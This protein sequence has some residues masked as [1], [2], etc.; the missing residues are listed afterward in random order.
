MNLMDRILSPG[1]AVPE[2][3]Y[4]QFPVSFGKLIKLVDQVEVKTNVLKNIKEYQFPKN[5][6]QAVKKINKEPA[7]TC[8]PF[9]GSMDLTYPKMAELKSSILLDISR[10]GLDILEVKGS[11][12]IIG[13]TASLEQM[14]RSEALKTITQGVIGQAA[15]LYASPAQRNSCNLQDIFLSQTYYYDLLTVLSLFEPTAVL[16]GKSKRSVAFSELFQG[17]FYSSHEKGVDILKEIQ[18]KIPKGTVAASLQRV[19]ITDADITIMGAAALVKFSGKKVAEIKIAVGSGT[20]TPLTFPEIE[21]SL[22]GQILTPELMEKTG[23]D[24]AQQI[25]TITDHRATADYRRQITA[26]LVKRAMQDCKTKAG[27]K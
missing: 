15:K 8:Y 14:V 16:I 25:T 13:G 21:A 22:K 23:A 17:A 18:F 6:S 3:N 2:N 12:V 1:I 7:G 26:V 20:A 19:A 9:T 24:I 11:K 27:K 4:L 10:L 5:L